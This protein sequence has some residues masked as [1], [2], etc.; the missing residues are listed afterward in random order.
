MRTPARTWATIAVLLATASAPAG[1]QT[2]EGD[3]NRDGQVTINEVVTAVV[4][5]LNGC[6]SPPPTA[7]PTSTPVPPRT[8]TP[9]PTPT[10]PTPTASATATRTPTPNL[11]RAACDGSF[12]QD[13]FGNRNI[14][15]CGFV[16]PWNTLCGRNDLVVGWA[17]DGFNILAGIIEPRIYITGQAIDRNNGRMTGWYTQPN[18]IDFRP[19]M[20]TL[21]MTSNTV[22]FN[23]LPTGGAPFAI[24]GCQFEA[25]TGR[26]FTDLDGFIQR[27]A[28]GAGV[29]LAD[30]VQ[31]AL[32]AELE[33]L[34]R[35]SGA[36][37]PD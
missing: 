30:E 25:Y 11:P 20:G 13:N 18:A 21:S 17:S 24:A 23:V 9:T 3:F 8:G 2:C 7:P 34:R 5:G 19:W 33:T 36:G 32:L 35:R 27:S 26:Y 22:L 4:N 1:A 29:S 6:P 31:A 10:A 37:A 28:T 15:V 14:P 16:G 12:F